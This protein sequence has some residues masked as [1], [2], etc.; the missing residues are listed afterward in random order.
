MFRNFSE[1][2]KMSAGTKVVMLIVEVLK[3][4]SPTWPGVPP[5]SQDNMC[6]EMFMLLRPIKLLYKLSSRKCQMKTYLSF[7]D[8]NL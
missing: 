2:A 5:S 7:E 6:F 4:S 1:L 8:G 3:M